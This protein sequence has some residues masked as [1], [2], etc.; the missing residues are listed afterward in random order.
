MANMTEE[1]AREVAEYRAR[2]GLYSTMA[3]YVP[4]PPKRETITTELWTADNYKGF[5]M[6][7]ADFI[8]DLEALLKK[9]PV[10][11]RDNAYINFSYESGCYDESGSCELRAYWEREETDA[12]IE[13]KALKASK[14]AESAK[15][16][17][18][19]RRKAAAAAELETLVRLMDKYNVKPQ[20]VPTEPID[21]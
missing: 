19:K 14:A 20:V 6:A 21:V 9:V 16:A 1:E 15:V 13:A 18:E 2:I 4:D 3:P 17:A 8:E 7:L 5:H 12:E 10:K 11:H